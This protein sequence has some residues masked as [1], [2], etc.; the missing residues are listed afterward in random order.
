MA[1]TSFNEEPQETGSSLTICAASDC[2]FAFPH[3]TAELTLL[4]SDAAWWAI[5]VF[6]VV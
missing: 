6:W 5:T 1:Y 3:Q 2:H 4:A